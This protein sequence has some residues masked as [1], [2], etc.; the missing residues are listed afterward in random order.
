MSLIFLKWKYSEL[1]WSRGSK[2]LTPTFPWT[3]VHLPV[4]CGIAELQQQVGA[5]TPLAHRGCAVH[6]VHSTP[7]PISPILPFLSPTHPLTVLLWSAQSCCNS[8]L[9]T[10]CG[11]NEGEMFSHNKGASRDRQSQNPEPHNHPELSFASTC[12]SNLLDKEQLIGY[13]LEGTAEDRYPDRAWELQEGP[14]GMLKYLTV[15]IFILSEKLHHFFF[16]FQ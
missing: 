6:L 15:V 14:S 16:C 11:W 12:L 2:R 9:T 1:R 4:Q 7:F 13:S 10:V 8:H 5:L 3:W